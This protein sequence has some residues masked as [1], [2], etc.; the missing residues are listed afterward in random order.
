MR[1]SHQGLHGWT[2]SLRYESGEWNVWLL[3]SGRV[4]SGYGGKDDPAEEVIQHTFAG[5]WK[6]KAAMIQ[7]NDFVLVSK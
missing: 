7:N 4:S 1:K 6:D 5:S 2:D 3:A